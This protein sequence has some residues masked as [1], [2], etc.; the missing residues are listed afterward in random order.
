MNYF[1]WVLELFGY[2]FLLVVVL[3]FVVPCVLI[4]LGYNKEESRMSEEDYLD[5]LENN[6]KNI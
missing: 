5:W 2:C 1:T 3:L 4:S 6:K